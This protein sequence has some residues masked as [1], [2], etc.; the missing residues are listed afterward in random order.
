MK[1]LWIA[2]GM[3][4]IPLG[5]VFLLLTHQG[6]AIALYRGTRLVWIQLPMPFTDSSACRSLVGGWRTPSD[7]MTGIYWCRRVRGAGGA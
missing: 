4:L 3:S 5:V 2:L 6:P 1:W 7:S